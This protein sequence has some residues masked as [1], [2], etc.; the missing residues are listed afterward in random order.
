MYMC[1]QD[2]RVARVARTRRETGARL[3]FMAGAVVRGEVFSTR[4]LHVYECVDESARYVCARVRVYK[5]TTENKV[6]CVTI[7]G[8]SLVCSERLQKGDDANKAHVCDG[9]QQKR[10]KEWIGPQAGRETAQGTTATPLQPALAI[11]SRGSGPCAHIPRMWHRHTRFCSAAPSRAEKV[12][13]VGRSASRAFGVGKSGKSR[14]KTR[15]PQRSR[16]DTC[17]G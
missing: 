13:A 16:Y 8:P 4:D 7:S 2:S 10:K 5:L 12:C 3:C 17:Q 11:K 14:A 9:G 1:A 6:A 15:V